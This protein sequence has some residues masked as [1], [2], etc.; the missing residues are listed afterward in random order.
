MRFEHVMHALWL[1]GLNPGERVLLTTL[2]NAA[3]PDRG[4]F[5]A[6][7]KLVRLTGMHP[8]TVQQHLR[9]L[10]ALG[11]IEETAQAKPG[12]VRTFMPHPERWPP[13]PLL[14]GTPALSEGAPPG[15]YDP[16]AERPASPSP[17][18]D[19]A[20]PGT[21]P[22]DDLPAPNRGAHARSDPTLA[23]ALATS[24]RAV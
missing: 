8:K 16:S 17:P 15:G 1:P 4:V 10:L 20:S 14:E 19:P 9:K 11:Y 18:D 22:E 21:A 3:S 12:Q 5:I 24:L 23:T 2:T 13:A 6:R 7:E